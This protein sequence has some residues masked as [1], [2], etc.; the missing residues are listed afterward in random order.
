MNCK[1]CIHYL[2]CKNWY[3]TLATEGIAVT[4]WD[5]DT[6][7]GLFDKKEAKNEKD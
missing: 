7:C 1:D 3:N 2:V 4:P 5:D 6:L